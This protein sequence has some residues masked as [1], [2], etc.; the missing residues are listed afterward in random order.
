MPQ[1]PSIPKGTRDFGPVE[2][3]RRTYIFDIIKSVFI[4][5]GY[6][7][8]ET[9][10]METLQTLLMLIRKMFLNGLRHIWA[11]YTNYMACP[12]GLLSSMQTQIATHGCIKLSWSS[13]SLTSSPWNTS[14][15]IAGSSLYQVQQITL[16]RMDSWLLLENTTNLRLPAPRY[17]I[18]HGLAQT[19]FPSSTAWVRII[20][21]VGKK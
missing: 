6:Q 21:K 2:M 18:R 20:K 16:T 7:P 8:I 4:K 9:P 5:F 17:L 11:G 13:R 3:L 10:A 12:S 1:K 14:K 15:D 19:T